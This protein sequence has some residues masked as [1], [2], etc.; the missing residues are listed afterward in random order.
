MMLFNTFSLQENY[1]EG[2]SF[3]RM[4]TTQGERIQMRYI[5]KTVFIFSSKNHFVRPGG[6]GR[7]LYFN[8]GCGTLIPDDT[9]EAQSL[10]PR[11][12]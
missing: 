4:A 8:A 9:G 2:A 6:R 11:K 7:G 1:T 3:W 5:I 10:S 12:L